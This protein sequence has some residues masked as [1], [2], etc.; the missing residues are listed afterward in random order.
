MRTR[1][2]CGRWWFLILATVASC[3]S[4]PSIVATVKAPEELDKLWL[5]VRGEVRDP[6]T[7]NY[8]LL[9]NQLLADPTKGGS[10]RYSD[11]VTVSIDVPAAGQYGLILIGW[12][13]NIDC[14]AAAANNVGDGGLGSIPDGGMPG[15]GDGHQYFF[16]RGVD[17]KE[18]STLSIDLYAVSRSA[19]AIPSGSITGDQCD[20]R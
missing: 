16:A 8:P 7:G 19:G 2:R 18:I 5:V 9:V 17:V 3:S 14:L 10:K 1:L 13:G 12:K 4:P 20:V 11:G 6:A 15:A